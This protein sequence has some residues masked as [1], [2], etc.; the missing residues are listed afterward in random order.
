[1]PNPDSLAAFRTTLDRLL[2]AV[3][4]DPTSDEVIRL[5]QQLEAQAGFSLTAHRGPVGANVDRDML[6]DR[7]GPL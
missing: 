4:N 6:K 5:K 1:M 7:S 3:R 2:V